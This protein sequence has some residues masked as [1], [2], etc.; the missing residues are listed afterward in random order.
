MRDLRTSILEERLP[1]FVN[2]FVKDYY[3][4]EKGVPEWVV[5]ALKHGGIEIEVHA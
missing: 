4:H 2:Q 1:Q 5:E 3:K